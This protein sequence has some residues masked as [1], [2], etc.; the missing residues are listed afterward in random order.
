[1]RTR[2]ISC[3]TGKLLKNSDQSSRRTMRP[4]RRKDRGLAILLAAIAILA[5][6]PPATTVARADSYDLRPLGRV[7]PVKDQNP[8]GNCWTYA[9]MASVESNML[10]RGLMTNP[11]SPSADFSE[12][13]LT[14]FYNGYD[15]G[16]PIA[17]GSRH[18]ALSYFSRG[19]GPVLE[20]QYPK[21][22]T[23]GDPYASY[24][25]PPQCWITA[26]QWIDRDNYYHPAT[27]Q[28]IKNAIVTHGV[29]ETNMYW[30]DYYYNSGSNS[31]YL[32]GGPYSTNHAVSL[33]GWDDA[34]ST[35][36]GSPGAWL[37]KNSWGPSWGNGG[38]FWLSYNDGSA[39]QSATSYQTAPAAK[40][41]D[42]L[43]NQTN[44]PTTFWSISHGAMKFTTDRVC[45][46]ESVG[47]LT[48]YH[49]VQYSV[50]VYDSW[51]AGKPSG[52]RATESGTYDW[53]GYYVVDFDSPLLLPA[54]DEFVVVLSLTGGEGSGFYLAMDTTCGDPA[55]LN[56]I[57][58]DGVSWYDAATMLGG[59]NVL[60]LKTFMSYIPGDATGD[61][62]VNSAD[63]NALAQHWGD[64]GADWAMGDF[65]ADGVVG[66]GDASILAANWNYNASE[67]MPAAAIPEP[68][69]VAMLASAIV[70]AI[71]RRTRSAGR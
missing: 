60:F 10:T 26:Q 20:S 3:R 36:S 61:G 65:D 42:V 44:A 64:S 71:L 59:D 39:V 16:Q 23:T 13:H 48:D 4:A 17:G 32:A 67:A 1:M 55:G 63:A 19:R 11:A 25:Y 40:Y 22:G 57:S 52:L 5:I 33:V 49:N 54:A 37:V 8:Y 34:R 43:E 14:R 30:S 31:Y 9:T 69:V 66:A 12:A 50:S 21:P 15:T 45:R 2:I 58:D 41:Q 53:P 6:V 56:Y 38:Y 47:F 62:L 18:E 7:T 28:D 51:T 68:T 29:V 27:F 35:Q 70:C 24:D 46:L